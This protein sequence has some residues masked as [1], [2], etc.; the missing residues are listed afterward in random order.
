MT[1]FLKKIE[2]VAGID[3]SL[4]SPAVCVAE[5]IDNE[6]KF[7]NCKFHFLKQNKSHKSLG[8]I[9]AYD[10][11]EY[12]DDIERFSNLASWTIECIR[13]FDGRVDK[14]YL[15]IMHLQ[16]Q[17]EFSILERILEYS[18]NNL[19]KLDSNKKQSHPQ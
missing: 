6:I 9:F 19:K 10:Y 11:P 14:V 16:R 7:E 5:I 17:E 1:N 3:Y 2:F 12:T 15:E 18:K 8:K 13:W 4:T